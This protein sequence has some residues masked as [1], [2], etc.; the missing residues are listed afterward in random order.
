VESV[1][2]EAFRDMYE[3]LQEIIELVKPGFGWK[4]PQKLKDKASLALAKAC[5]AQEEWDC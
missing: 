1:S 3:V 5:F 2:K 4:L